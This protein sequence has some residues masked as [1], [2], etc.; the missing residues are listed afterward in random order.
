M[1]TLSGEAVVSDS[2]LQYAYSL[3]TG[4]SIRQPRIT[5]IRQ[6][7]DGYVEFQISGKLVMTPAEEPKPDG[8]AAAT[9]ESTPAAPDASTPAPVDNKPE[10]SLPPTVGGIQ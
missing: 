10:L 7:E 1:V 5:V 2:V 3:G 4:R 8:G 6:R 9:P